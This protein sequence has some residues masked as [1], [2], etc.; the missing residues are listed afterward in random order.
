MHETLESKI[1]KPII[2]R[3]P[4][5]FP[6]PDASVLLE[7]EWLV[8]NGLGGYASSTISGIGTRKYHGILVAAM[9]APFGRMM[10]LN[11]VREDILFA[12]GAEAELGGELLSR[13]D[14]LFP[15]GYHLQEFILEYGLP[16]WRYRINDTL[17]EKRIVLPHF[18]NTVFINYRLVSGTE[19]TLRLRPFMQFRSLHS[20]LS[21]RQEKP[22]T[23]HALGDRFEIVKNPETP[24]LRFYVFGDQSGLNLTGG[25][26]FERFYRSEERRGYPARGWSWNPG[27]FHTTLSQNNSATLIASAEPWEVLLALSPD[28]VIREE[29]ARRRRLLFLARE[30]PTNVHAELILAADQFIITPIARTADATRARARGDESRTVIAGYHWFTDWGRD[31]MISLEG[32]CLATG[33]RAEA[34]YILRTFA[35]YVKDGLIP[36][37]FP[38]GE[39][40]GRYNTADATLWF[41]HA[42]DRYFRYSNDF[43]TMRELLPVLLDII[44][45]HIRGTRFGIHMDPVDGLLRQGHDSF[46]LTWMDAKAGDWIVT[47]RRGKTVEINALWYNA[48]R[49][50]RQWLQETD[51]SNEAGKLSELGDQVQESF[52]EKFW[53]EN[54]GY[55][56][57][58]IEGENGKDHS[59]RPNQ[60]FSISLS[61]PV[62]DSARWKAVLSTVEQHLLTPVG[63]R[64]LDPCHPHYK[65]EY[66]GDLLA[67]DGAYHQGSVWSWLIGPFIDAWLKVYPDER[68]KARRFIDGLVAHLDD[69]CVGNVSEIFDGEPPFRYEGCVAQAWSV[70]ELLRSLIQVAQ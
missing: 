3:I 54:G 18:Q 25:Y 9:P 55:L 53:Y 63:L 8:T 39:T 11:D 58:I 45:H 57:D 33:R 28:E 36:N 35:H 47:P 17:I 37:M 10:M 6:E 49:L 60:I 59:L 7:R 21:A 19:A 50:M 22:Y 67:R 62:L 56:Y 69:A 31:T 44:N 23:V 66:R 32:L 5:N 12:D 1:L 20:E 29:I 2:R 24:S 13:G 68:E 65:G 14:L 70:A 38:E 61:H 52:N 16:L 34:G 46:A 41:F 4:L 64:S 42:I 15:G 27:F 43:I 40:E 48:L 26:A 30:I 51:N